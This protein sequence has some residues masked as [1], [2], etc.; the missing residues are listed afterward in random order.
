MKERRKEQ[1][2][3]REREIE[4][5]REREREREKVLETEMGC[6]I[7]VLSCIFMTNILK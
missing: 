3:E 5:E 6:S 7:F 2:R 4:R 1:E